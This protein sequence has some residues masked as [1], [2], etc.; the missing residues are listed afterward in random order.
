MLNEKSDE[1]GLPIWAAG[2]DFQKVFD[3]VEQEENWRA[4]EEQQV[5]VQ[6]I[7]IFKRLYEGQT[8]VV[9]TGRES[10]AF[11]MTRGT[12]QGDP[13]SPPHLTR[14]WKRRW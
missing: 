14:Y 4:L 5:P 2:I 1:W 7:Q 9:V 11:R 13:A 3:T 8:G 10:G 6:Y 12:K